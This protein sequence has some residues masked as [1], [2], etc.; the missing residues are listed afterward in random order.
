MAAK[1][2]AELAMKGEVQA[3]KSKDGYSI[4]TFAGGCFWYDGRTCRR[5]PHPHTVLIALVLAANCPIS[6]GAWSWPT[7][8][9]RASSTPRWGTRRGR[10]T[11]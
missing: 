10:R 11:R 4:G 6:T 7:S 3:E 8:A 9:C 1:E 5:S 2:A